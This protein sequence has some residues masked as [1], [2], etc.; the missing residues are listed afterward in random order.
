MNVGIYFSYGPAS[1]EQA[2]SKQSFDVTKRGERRIL[3]L[4]V[5]LRGTG[6][7]GTREFWRKAFLKLFLSK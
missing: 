2:G 5:G 3:N 6:D 7:K 4:L 1:D